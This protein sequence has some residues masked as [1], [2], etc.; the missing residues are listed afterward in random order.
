MKNSMALALMAGALVGFAGCEEKKPETTPA[1]STTKAPEKSDAGKMV[2]SAKEAGTKAVDAT[3]DAAAKA[4]DA[5]K[6][7]GTKMVDA[8]K[9][10]G[11]K[12]VE[13]AKEAVAAAPAALS[14]DIKKTVT[15]YTSSLSNFGGLLEGVKSP[16]DVAGKLGKI[17]DGAGSL[18][19]AYATL[20]KYSPDIQSSIKTT[21]KDQLEPLTKKVN[22]QIARISADKTLG[23]SLGDVLKNVKL[24]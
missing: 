12:T 1:P 16:L 7:T 11:T 17:K 10:A 23:A 8:A 21:F 6:D 14:D 9:D 3:K 5:A 20:E 4:V 24:F 18:S 19:A 15:D 22:D 2:D 13:K